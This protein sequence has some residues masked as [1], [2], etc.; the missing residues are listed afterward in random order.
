MSKYIRN[1]DHTNPYDMSKSYRVSNCSE[2]YK[3]AKILCLEGFLDHVYCYKAHITCIKALKVT[4]KVNVSNLG[5]Y[6][7]QNKSNRTIRSH[8]SRKNR[9]ALQFIKNTKIKC[10]FKIAFC[11]Q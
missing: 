2:N 11:I 1:I 4:D 5:H 7:S 9:L 8:A 10:S 6:T 3:L